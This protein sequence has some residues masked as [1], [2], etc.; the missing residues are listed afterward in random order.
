[1]NYSAVAPPEQDNGMDPQSAFADALARARQVMKRCGI[2][3]CKNFVPPVE[4]GL[5][6][7]GRS[8][9][10]QEGVTTAHGMAETCALNV[11]HG[12]FIATYKNFGDFLGFRR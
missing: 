3:W 2:F 10:F 8:V 4:N 5:R 1:M 7:K 12:M 9:A 6:I 11:G